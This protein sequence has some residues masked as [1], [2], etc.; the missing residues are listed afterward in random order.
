MAIQ[1]C[2]GQWNSI[3][4]VSTEEQVHVLEPAVLV[5]CPTQC[6]WSGSHIRP[7]PLKRTG[8]NQYVAAHHASR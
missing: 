7:V 3:V 8:D 5:T 1:T 4:T 2:E 6:N